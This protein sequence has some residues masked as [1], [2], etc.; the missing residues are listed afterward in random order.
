MVQTYNPRQKSLLVTTTIIFL[1][2]FLITSSLSSVPY[3]EEDDFRHHQEA[4]R[5]LQESSSPASSVNSLS[6]EG[7]HRF[8]AGELISHEPQ[9][10]EEEENIHE[11]HIRF[12]LGLKNNIISAERLPGIRNIKCSADGVYLHLNA[13]VNPILNKSDN[14]LIAEQEVL[15]ANN[16]IWQC[17]LPSFKSEEADNNPQTVIPDNVLYRKIQSKGLHFYLNNNHNNNNMDVMEEDATPQVQVDYDDNVA[18]PIDPLKNASI[19]I[20]SPQMIH[21]L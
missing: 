6:S 13:E 3:A 4:L 14:N 19:C 8:F 5:I 10:E 17:S 15:V 20:F 2:S 16:K 1:I 18:Q 9:D 7:R 12:N 11:Q 21:H